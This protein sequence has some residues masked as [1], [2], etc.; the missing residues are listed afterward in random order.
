MRLKQ[1][2]PDYHPEHNYYLVLFCNKKQE[3]V[4]ERVRTLKTAKIKYKKMLEKVKPPFHQERKNGKRVEYFLGLV[5]NWSKEQKIEFTKDYLG[6]NITMDLRPFQSLVM[7]NPYWVEEKIW[8][9]Q[10]RQR[11]RFEDIMIL[12]DDMPGLK[13]IYKLNS[14]IL[15]ETDEI[16]M[17]SAKTVLDAM[18]FINLTIETRISEGKTDCLFSKDVDRIH[19]QY[20]YEHLNQYGIDK[21]KVLKHFTR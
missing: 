20:L 8:D 13:M 10:R 17:F 21:K 5:D 9:N 19:R 1:F 7:I 4:I 12:L 16:L 15:I 2:S 14:H 18:R 11:I 3:K 6:R